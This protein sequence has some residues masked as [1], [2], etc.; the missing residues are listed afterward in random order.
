MYSQVSEVLFIFFNLF[1][2]CCL[3][4]VISILSS[5]LLIFF[6]C[7]LQSV[8]ES[9]HWVFS[10]NYCIFQFYNFH[11]VLLY[12]FYFFAETFP[13][14][15][16][17]LNYCCDG[18]WMACQI[19]LISVSSQCW[20]LLSFSFK[21]DFSGSCYDKWFF[22]KFFNLGYYVVKLWIFYKSPFLADVFDTML[23][24]TLFHYYHSVF[25]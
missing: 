18:W 20:C 23:V 22:I 10:F 24:G 14:C 16:C 11:L 12:I 3:Y 8:V 1:S 21:W 9:I 7:L 15:N 2:L 17:S 19:I 13:V 5:S 6:L 25:I 4:W